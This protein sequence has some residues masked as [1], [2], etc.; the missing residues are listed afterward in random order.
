MKLVMKM[1]VKARKL[2]VDGSETKGAITAFGADAT[3][4]P[5]ICFVNRHRLL[6]ISDSDSK[7]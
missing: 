3:T 5:A 6:A 2:T 1:D 7:P 4:R